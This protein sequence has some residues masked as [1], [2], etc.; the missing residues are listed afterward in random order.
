MRGFPIFELNAVGSRTILGLIISN[1]CDLASEN[2]PTPDQRVVYAPIL[3]LDIYRERLIGRGYL[4][5]DADGIINQ[6]RRQE[7]VRL[8]Y[9]PAVPGQFGESVIALDNLYSLPLGMLNE[10]RRTRV[11]SLSNFGW[12]VLLFKLSVHF[13]RMTDAVRR[14]SLAGI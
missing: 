1:S 14:E 4:S 13:T 2:N 3:N 12:Y 6:I 7:V 11:F 8:F 5:K 9:L 10:E